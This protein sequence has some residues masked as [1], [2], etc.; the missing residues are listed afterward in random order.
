MLNRMVKSVSRDNKRLWM[1][2]PLLYISGGIFGPSSTHNETA[3]DE[4][5]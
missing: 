2:Q 1:Y 4:E 5:G 3:V